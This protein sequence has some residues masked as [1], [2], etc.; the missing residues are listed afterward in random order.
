[1][2]TRR[3]KLVIPEMGKARIEQVRIMFTKA[4]V[5]QEW[6]LM[7]NKGR[8]LTD[9]VYTSYC[10][11]CYLRS[12]EHCKTLEDVVNFLKTWAYSMDWT[13]IGTPHE[14]KSIVAEVGKYNINPY[15][16]EGVLYWGVYTITFTPGYVHFLRSG[17][18]DDGTHEIHGVRHLIGLVKLFVGGAGLDFVK[19]LKEIEID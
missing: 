2:K 13:I 19:K 17:I 6:R 1:M 9:T 5:E 4:G 18:T 12:V 14:Q 7:F 8:L 16:L 10:N 15:K 3:G 11:T